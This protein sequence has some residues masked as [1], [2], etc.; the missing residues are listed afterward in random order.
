MKHL[1]T[2]LLVC[3][4][5]ACTRTVYLTET[6]TRH[7]TDTL[8]HTALV[9]RLIVERDSVN[10]YTRGDTVYRDV[11]K[12]RVRE[13]KSTDT[14]YKAVRDTVAVREPY[15]VEVEKKLTWVQRLGAETASLASFFIIAVV[16]IGLLWIARKIFGR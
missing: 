16:L 7:T 13:T 11:T 5:S 6:E 2:V 9:E 12:W 3:M 4:L 15:A 8:H 10:I 1:I 14:V